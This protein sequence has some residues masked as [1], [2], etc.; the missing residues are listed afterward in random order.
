M[1]SIHRL[2][3]ALLRS[4]ASLAAAVPAFRSGLSVPAASGPYLLAPAAG[5]AARRGPA[6]AVRR[7]LRLSAAEGVVAEVV[8]AT[9]GPTVLTG[10]ALHLGAG[11]VAVGLLGALPFLSQLAQLPAAWLTAALGRRRVAVVAVAVSRQALLPLAALPFL[12]VDA[13]AKR[14]LLFAIAAVSAVFA[15]VGNNAW[16]AWM[17]ELVPE[18]LRGRYF[19]RRTALCTAGGTAA[20]LAAGLLLD[21]AGARGAT[22]LA[23]STLA[24]ASSIAGLATARLL[25]SQHEPAAPPAAR[26]DLRASLRPLRDPAARGLLG[27][28][29]AWNAAVG[30]GGAYFTLHLLGNVG[31]GFT[32][33]ALH[34]TAVAGVRVLAAPLWGRAIDRLGARPV[35]A[36]CSG[37]IGLL[38]VLWILCRP[39]NLWPLAFDAALSG[40][41]WSGHGLAVFAA[42]LAVAPRSERPF[43]LAAFTV[44]GGVAY[45]AGTAA[46]GLLAEVLPGRLDLA[47][48]RAF[49]L[50]VVFALSALGRLWAAGLAPRI[51]ERGAGS[52][53]ELAELVRA[54]VRECV[55]RAGPAR[56]ARPATGERA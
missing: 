33:L 47:G 8:A 37:V 55:R 45:A 10:W 51:A 11:P 28:Q 29:L 39:G 38:P 25:W 2:S 52:V 54:S 3:R 41:A 14:A 40:V 24:V 46:G 7:S 34:A 35:L 13:P 50:H 18:R 12:P 21:H 20:G 5:L 17:G 16:V 22:G 31:V 53:A 27:Y 23:L 30:V 19:G 42:P 56:E 48:H 9:A 6:S 32:L 44:A 49:G 4:A 36:T 1:P 26:P 15:V 43:Y